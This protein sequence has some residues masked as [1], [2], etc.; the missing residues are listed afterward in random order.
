MIR[1]GA[2]TGAIGLSAGFVGGLFGVG[3]GVLMVPGLVLLLSVTQHRAHAT[4][5]AAIVAAS[6]AAAVPLAAG[7]RVHWA[8][9]GLLLAGSA[10]GAWLGAGAMARVSDVW[11]ARSFLVLLI[12]AAARMA[13][14]SGGGGSPE[15]TAA[16]VDLGTSA[17]GLVA[18]GLAA[19]GLAAVLGIGGGVVYV[20]ALATLYGFPQHVAQATSLAV[21]LPTVLVATVAH[22]RGRRVDWRLAVMLSL[23]GVAGGV[24][25]AMTALHL[26]GWLLRRLFAALLVVVGL[27]MVRKTVRSHAPSPA[28][29]GV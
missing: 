13:L 23:G 1:I 29:G 12:A 3:G 2:V 6:A 14:P 8:A 28:A 19:G 11:L 18:V 5:A 26:E 22:A 20:P 16:A 17:V 4:S 7:D 24:G 25:G 9:A 27:R 15:A 21:I 10:V